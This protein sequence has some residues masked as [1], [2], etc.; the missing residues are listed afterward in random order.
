MDEDS[1]KRERRK[2]NDDLWPSVK[3]R[4]GERSRIN[5]V[6]EQEPF[7]FLFGVSYSLVGLALDGEKRGRLSVHAKKRRQ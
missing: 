1:D 2:N 4:E 7:F 6:A 5:F 3:K